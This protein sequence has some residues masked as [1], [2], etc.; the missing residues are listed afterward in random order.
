MS[1]HKAYCFEKETVLCL[2]LL[3]KMHD[4]KLIGQLL[5][6]VTNDSICN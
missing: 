3:T 4:A 2:N 6:I 5:R 1:G